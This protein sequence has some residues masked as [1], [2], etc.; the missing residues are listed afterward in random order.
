MSPKGT[1]L[2]RPV[3]GLQLAF[4]PSAART[5]FANPTQAAPP[6]ARYASATDGFRPDGRKKL[7]KAAGTYGPKG[8]T[9]QPL[10]VK[11]L[12]VDLLTLA[13]TAESRLFTIKSP[14]TV[15]ALI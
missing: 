15:L 3:A 4:R 6:E 14:R 9:P 1:Q 10:T 12:S 11:G 5:V 7:T 2:V 13:A 8:P